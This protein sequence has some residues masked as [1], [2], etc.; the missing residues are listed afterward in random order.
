MHLS[1]VYRTTGQEENLHGYF[2]FQL[3]PRWA[4]IQDT[5]NGDSVAKLLSIWGPQGQKAGQHEVLLLNDIE[6]C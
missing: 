2:V 5:V 3:L 4:Q 1:A 6:Y